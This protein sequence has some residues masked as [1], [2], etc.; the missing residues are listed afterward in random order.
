MNACRAALGLTTVAV[1]LTASNFAH[2]HTLEGPADASSQGVESQIRHIEQIEWPRA[3][4]QGD[5]AWFQ[6]H[7]ADELVVT[8]GRTGMVTTKAQEIADIKPANLQSGSETIDDLRV[9][10]YGDVAIATFRIDVTGSDKSGPYH[11][12]ARYTDVWVRRDGRWQLVASHSSLIPQQ[13][14]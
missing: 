6:R 8:T 9:R 1:I 2:P 7:L 14:K 4:K 12:L 10:A 13:P 3:L 11:R 5:V